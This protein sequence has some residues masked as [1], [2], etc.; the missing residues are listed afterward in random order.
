MNKIFKVKE[1]LKETAIKAG[2]DSFGV[3]SVEDFS[4]EESCKIQNWLECGMNAE[5]KYLERSLPTKISPRK[6]F[7]DA[8]SAICLSANFYRPT[9]DNRIATYAQGEDYHNVLKECVK[10]IVKK[11][12]EL[13]GSYK[14][15]IDASPLWEKALARRA[16]IGWIGKNTLIIR[17]ENGAWSFLCI[18]LTSL[19]LPF[20]TPIAESCGDCEACIKS[21]PSNA[22]SE[23]GLDARKCI[24]YLTI[25]NKKPLSIEESKLVGNKIFGCDICLRA[26]PYTANAPQPKIEKFNT[27]IELPKSPTLQDILKV[28]KSTP[29]SRR[30]KQTI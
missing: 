28:A 1:L 7:E 20:D 23:K 12:E 16:G 29:M 14:V 6:F 27:K 15:S 11:I 26:C 17:K 13:G 25:E 4:A 22:I 8:K 18:I 19:E 9:E 3:C 5:M 2:F 30:F 21:C 24:S 10:P